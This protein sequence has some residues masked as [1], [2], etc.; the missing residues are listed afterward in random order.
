ME[1]NT[2]ILKK[3]ELGSFRGI[4]TKNFRNTQKESAWWGISILGKMHRCTDGF[5]RPHSCIWEKNTWVLWATYSNQ[6]EI[7]TDHFACTVTSAWQKTTPHI[8]YYEKCS[9]ANL[10]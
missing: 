4:F 10:L 7:F 5:K 6:F 9:E 1:N 3:L 2:K 8:Y